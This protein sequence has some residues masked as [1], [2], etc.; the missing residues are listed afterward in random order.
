MKGVGEGKLSRV[1][2]INP[3]FYF[4]SSIPR[5]CFYIHLSG[6]I[7]CS[8]VLQGM[9]KLHSYIRDFLRQPGSYYHKMRKN[10]V[11]NFQ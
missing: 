8:V 6:D 4:S 1:E 5:E 9:Q 2:F 3:A 10:L 11:S 7:S